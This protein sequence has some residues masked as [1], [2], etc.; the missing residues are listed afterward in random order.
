MQLKSKQVRSRILSG[1]EQQPLQCWCISA[2]ME[3]KAEEVYIDFSFRFVV[4]QSLS[5]PLGYST[6]GSS[7]LHY[8]SEF[9]QIQ[10]HWVSD[11][12]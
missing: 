10:V 7:G 6:L 9:A 11:A 4:V 5:Q 2:E 8:L 1:V 12:I 3:I